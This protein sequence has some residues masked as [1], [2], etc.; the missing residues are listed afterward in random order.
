MKLSAGSSQVQRLSSPVSWSAISLS[1][2]SGSSL[3]VTCK[4][5]LAGWLF[6]LPSLTV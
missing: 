1:C 5:I 3:A 6:R 4:V 2:R